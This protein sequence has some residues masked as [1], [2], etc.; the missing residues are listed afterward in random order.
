MLPA[1][2][3]IICGSGWYQ[4]LV[5]GTTP[6]MIHGYGEIRDVFLKHFGRKVLWLVFIVVHF[7]H[8]DDISFKGLNQL[9]I[10]SAEVT[11]DGIFLVGEWIA[12]YR[13]HHQK[14]FVFELC[15]CSRH[16]WFASWHNHLS[17][18][19]YLKVFALRYLLIYHM[20]FSFPPFWINFLWQQTTTTCIGLRFNPSGLYTCMLL[21][22]D[23]VN[24]FYRHCLIHIV[25]FMFL[26]EGVSP[27]LSC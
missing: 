11:E 3:H 27:K 15:C 10:K 21:F 26:Q 6:W 18:P 19:F 17:Y 13:F 9:F 24:E 25:P 12:W 22:G 7:M 14:I 5:C 20:K 23:Q 1:C 4:L 8:I 2:S 16:S